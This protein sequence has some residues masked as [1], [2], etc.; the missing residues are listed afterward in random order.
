MIYNWKNNFNKEQYEKMIQEYRKGTLKVDECIGQVRIGALCFDVITREYDLLTL[1][2]DL[3]VGGVD[4]GYGYS[5][6]AKG[7]PYDYVDGGDLDV[8][9]NLQNVNYEQFIKIAEEKFT[10]FLEG[11]EESYRNKKNISLL[12]KAEEP[13]KIW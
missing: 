3:Y 11:L 13:L 6:L 12:K 4:T 8:L 2:F 5:T 1:D 10:C 9:N 7:Y